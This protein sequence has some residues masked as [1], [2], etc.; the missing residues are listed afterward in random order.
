MEVM[1]KGFVSDAH[2][3]KYETSSRSAKME[4]VW[5]L[6]TWMLSIFFVI[7]IFQN[8]Q[9]YFLQHESSSELLLKADF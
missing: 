3:K 1:E 5:P 2:V 6:E 8:E 4:W 7:Y 9:M